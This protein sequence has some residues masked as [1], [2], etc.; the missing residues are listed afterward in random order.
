MSSGTPLGSDDDALSSA[1]NAASVLG[2]PKSLQVESQARAIGRAEGGSVGRFAMD[3]WNWVCFVLDK[4]KC[5][6][7]AWL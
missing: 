7:C 3:A 1:D 2:G 5:L 4:K 6:S